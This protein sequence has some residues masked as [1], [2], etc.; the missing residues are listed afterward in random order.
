[1]GQNYCNV[2]DIM[3]IDYYLGDTI[4]P[5][6]FYIYNTGHSILSKDQELK[7]RNDADRNY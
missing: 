6:D 7:T 1:M 3:I 2:G 5:K 4:Y